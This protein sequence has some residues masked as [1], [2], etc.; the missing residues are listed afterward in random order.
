MNILVTGSSGQIGT[1]LGLTLTARGDTVVGI[2]RR[3]N[4]WTDSITTHLMDLCTTSQKGFPRDVKY[5]VVVHLAAH[6][7]VFELV[8]FPDRAVENFTAAFNVLEFARH[9]RIP[10][11]FGSSREV[12]G[13][14]Q[15]HVT[16]EAAADFVVSESP[17]SATKLAVEAM[18]YSY[19]RCYELP[20]LVL[21]FS[22]VYGRYDND[23]ERMERVTP[24]FVRAIARDEPI[25]V[26]GK[27]K[28]LD[29]T[30]VDDCTDGVV[31]AIDAVTS[32][33]IMNETV[34]L[35]Y[36]RG[37]TLGDLVDI[38]SLALGKT[39]KV[40]YEPSRKGEVTHYVAD[41]TK[42]RELLGYD[43]KTSL[44]AGIPLALAWQRQVGAIPE[45]V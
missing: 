42:A 37:S 40:T 5:D 43:P 18:I 17:Y 22:N 25:T 13:D 39:A 6:A 20:H 44:I 4:T 38:I 9:E 1:N 32:G 7:K 15:R 45:A 16:D 14:I 33:R 31:R 28:V 19:W 21:R 35:A 24:L 41:L 26:F 10:I 36:G 23:L 12:Y 29:F 27:D 34:N 11:V 3:R 2:D 30:H 8:E